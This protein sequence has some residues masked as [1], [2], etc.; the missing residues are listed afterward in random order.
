MNMKQKL[1]DVLATGVENGQVPGV[2]AAMVDKNG[3]TYIGSAGERTIGTG[4]VMTTDTVGDIASM[5]KAITGAAVMQLVEQGLLDLDAPAETYCSELATPQVLEGF[6]D[7]GQPILRDA[8]SQVTLRNLLTHTAGYAYDFYDPNLDKWFGVT[9]A[10]LD[11]T[12][13]LRTLNTPLMFDPG[14]KWS[15]GIGIDWAGIILERVTK[16]KLGDYFSEHL[17]EPLGMMDTGFTCTPDMLERKAAMHLRTPDSSFMSFQIPQAETSEF[18]RGGGGLLSTMS[19]YARFMRMI[20]NDGELDGTRV[21]G[22]ETVAQMATNQLGDIPVTGLKT[23]NPA[24]FGDAD[25][26][27]GIPKSWGLSFL[28]NEEPLPNGCPAGALTWA[29]AFNSYFWIDK[30]TGIAGCYMSQMLPFF[31]AGASGNFFDFQN[32]VYAS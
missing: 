17:F 31:D 30:T 26:Y 32:A 14:T 19:D 7:A 1:D 2:V 18:D 8:R 13:R 27:P 24:I 10:Q 20:L 29:G 12:G 9:D 5:T 15:Y 16:S 11:H 3:L 25:F 6:D 23:V 22:P 21:L 28:I 4:D